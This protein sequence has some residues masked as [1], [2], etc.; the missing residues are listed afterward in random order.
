MAE[1]R[2]APRR[3]TKEAGQA[4]IS[5]RAAVDCV[6]RDISSTGARI[7][8]RQ[9]TFLPRTFN[10]RLKEEGDQKVTV[11]W[12]GGLLAGVRFQNPLRT[13]QPPKKRSLFGWR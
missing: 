9:P 5:G 10:L 1:H 12:Q 2:A 3:A 11:M 13:R 6:I 7:S 4:I 8:F